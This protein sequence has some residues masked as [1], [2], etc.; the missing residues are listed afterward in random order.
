MHTADDALVSARELVHTLAGVLPARVIETHISWVLLGPELAWKIKKPVR[1]PFVDYTGLQARRHFCEEEVRL[2]R[3]LAPSLYLGVT[4]ITG[5]PHSPELDGEGPVLEYAVRMR[6]FAPGALFSE[7]ADAGELG[8][9][10][11]DELAALLAGFHENAPRA[12]AAG[13]FAGAPQ[14]RQAALAALDGARPLMDDAAHAA[15]GAWLEAEAAALAP[16]WA[17]RLA[18]GRVRECHGDL[19]LANIVRLDDGV[20]AFDGI[21]F[22]PALRWIDVID[23][24][25]FVVMDLWANQQ[26][27]LCFRFLNA[28]LD[29]TGEHGGLPALRFAVV[30]RALVR[31]QVAQL[32]DAGSPAARRYLD[33]ALAWAAPAAA[34]ASARLSITHGLPGSGKTFASQ[35]IVEHEGAIRL[36]SDVERKRL[37]GLGM[38]EDSRAKGVD[39]YQAEAGARTYAHLFAMARTALRAG[40]PVILDAAFLRR[41]ERDQAHAL[42][43]DLRVPFGIVDCEAPL[44]VLRARLLAR[45]GDAS[46]ADGAVLN[47][48]RETA[49][50][51]SSSERAYAQ[52]PLAG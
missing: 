11:I 44:D 47:R 20:A 25:A 37:H 13:G 16:L 29:V 35:R 30:Y 38:L 39:L 17:A 1:L 34:H 21:E 2:N 7:K 31:A 4:R 24:I 36:R 22:D 8:T 6:R 12:D 42:A 45:R 33:T 15:L 43:L 5:T 27:D 49:E 46:E 14:R 9:A 10:D 51:L 19:H 23:D 48:L 28:W 50:P 26:R 3:R 52:A 41:A 40:Y 18:D 32:R